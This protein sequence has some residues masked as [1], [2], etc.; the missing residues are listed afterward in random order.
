MTSGTPVSVFISYSRE[1]SSFVDRLEADLQAR[2][3]RTW[4][5][6]RRLEGGQD[7][8][9][10]IQQAI[11]QCDVL[12]VVLSPNA[13]ASEYVRM[14]YRHARRKGKLVIPLE[15]KMC[16][17]VPMDLNHIQWVNFQKAYGQ[18]LNDLLVVLSNIKVKKPAGTNF[19]SPE[20]P[21][22]PLPLKNDEASFVA[23]QPASPQPSLELDDLYRAGFRAKVGGD[24][25]HAYVIW[26]QVLDR[27][28][29]FGNGT[30]ASS[31]QRLKEDLNPIRV[32]RLRER[33]ETAH[34]KGEWGQAIGAWEALLGLEPEDWQAKKDIE[35][36]RH[37]QKYA[38]L[39]ESAVRFLDE[40]GDIASAR[41]SLTELWHDAPLYGDP[42][43][44]AKDVKLRAPSSYWKRKEDSK[45]YRFITSVDRPLAQAP[46]W[47]GMYIFC[48]LSGVGV[49]TGIL[50][51]SWLLAVGTVVIV[52]LLSYLLGYHK[53][54]N[55]L[56][57]FIHIIISN[58]IT[59]FSTYYILS[60]IPSNME[61]NSRKEFIDWLLFGTIWV[62][63]FC[64]LLIIPS[65]R[66]S[67]WKMI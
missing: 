37:N 16:K 25:E 42:L 32:E 62:M 36:A 31:F 60:I 48:L 22:P 29:E 49:T 66:R 47:L 59:F 50:A 54:V 28:P 19:P 17:E 58:I 46:F 11:E 23:P 10:K 26:Q 7:W 13:V 51:Q 30:L 52:A 63:L 5:D 64:L 56:T 40:D 39:Y 34:I 4:V 6:R 35:I 27:D 53:V 24:L 41:A 15:Y 55:S 45:R 38:Y 33:A 44:L 1:D 2:T 12:L 20:V 67:I 65:N 14:E 43:G 9:D 57:M 8:L 21:M 18:G 61:V 3:F